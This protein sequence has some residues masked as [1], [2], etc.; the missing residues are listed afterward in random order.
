MDWIAGILRDKIAQGKL[1]P[2]TKLSEEEICAT[3]AISRNTLRTAFTALESERIVTRY[4]NR[5]VFVA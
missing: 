4:P 2:G 3:L 1:L 5:G